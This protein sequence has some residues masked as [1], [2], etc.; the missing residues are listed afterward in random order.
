[1]KIGDNKNIFDK[2]I[3]SITKRTPVP[4]KPASNIKS[5]PSNN[6]SFGIDSKTTTSLPFSATG[7]KKN[8]GKK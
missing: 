2:I 8:N 3:N 7:A 4:K 1:M 6:L 5:L